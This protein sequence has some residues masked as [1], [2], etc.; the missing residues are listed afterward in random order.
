M[1]FGKGV[2]VLTKFM[3]KIEACICFNLQLSMASLHP[4]VSNGYLLKSIRQDAVI[5][6][7][8]NFL[9]RILQAQYY[10]LDSYT[11]KRKKF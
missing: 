4:C 3:C 11:M 6:I 2:N 10:D 9:L 1:K 8:E 5:V 7:L